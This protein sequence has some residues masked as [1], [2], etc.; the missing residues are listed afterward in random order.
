VG[1]NAV[2]L[3]NTHLIECC[4]DDDAPTSSEVHGN[5]PGETQ[6]KGALI[7]CQR[8]TKVKR[9]NSCGDRYCMDLILSLL[10]PHPRMD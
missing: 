10:T 4:I 1:I 5:N 3:A 8:K 6:K 7:L 9:S 2:P